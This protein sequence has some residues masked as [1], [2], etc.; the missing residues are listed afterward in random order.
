MTIIHNE[1]L[2]LP[3][4]AIIVNRID[5]RHPGGYKR[6]QKQN[7]PFMRGTMPSLNFEAEQI[8]F[9][10][11]YTDNHEL[12]QDAVEFIRSL[13]TSLLSQAPGL[14][15]PTVISRIKD[16]EESIRKFSRKYQTELEQKQQ[17]Y[18]IKD[19]IT[20]LLGI[21]VIC[22][23]ER[24]IDT[25]VEVLRANFHILDESDK[26]KKMEN[27]EG[28][29]GY[30]GFH[31]DLTVNEARKVLPEYARFS[32]LRYEVQVRTI[33]QDAWSVLD[34]KIKYKKS[35]PAPLKRRINTLAAL[36]ELA[37]HEFLS[38]RDETLDLQQQADAKVEAEA[39]TAKAQSSSIPP[40]EERSA[41]LD[42]F[43]FLTVVKRY[44]PDYNFLNLA[45]DGFVQEILS[46]SELTATK[47]DTILTDKLPLVQEYR[48]QSP[49]TLNPFTQIRHAL[50]LSDK[51]HSRAILFDKQ[52]AN[53]EGWL[54]AKG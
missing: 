11:Y 29:F 23:Y 3:C 2:S 15:K 7:A 4:Q 41:P 22:L 45:V 54:K 48:D 9:R 34:H 39:E 40:A 16:R 19:F 36:F 1:L 8:S 44:F 13:V 12:L 14:E 35:I 51:D 5:S 20:D 10:N 25:V 32:N 52:R 42:V 47:L 27:T 26:I 21:R 6:P 49:Y 43:S 31:L 50:Y 33:I 24:E 37:D 30:K 38:I 17:P 18:E 28:T 46:T 53:F